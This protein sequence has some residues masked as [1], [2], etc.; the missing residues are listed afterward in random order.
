MTNSVFAVSV[1]LRWEVKVQNGK[2]EGVHEEEHESGR[3]FVSKLKTQFNDSR[4]SGTS[5]ITNL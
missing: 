4:V 1:G 2:H 3:K 5:E